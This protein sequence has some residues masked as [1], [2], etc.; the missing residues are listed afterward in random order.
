MEGGLQISLVFN[1]HVLN[2]S[3]SNPY[4]C[5]EIQNPFHFYKIFATFANQIFGQVIFLYQIA[6]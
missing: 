1:H 3:N 4:H 2:Y 5:Q 6:P